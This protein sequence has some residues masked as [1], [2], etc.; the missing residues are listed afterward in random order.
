MIA[1]VCHLQ[2]DFVLHLMLLLLLLVM[3][4]VM[5]RR[6]LCK[7]AERASE[8]LLLLLLRLCVSSPR[9]RSVADKSIRRRRRVA[10]TY[11]EHSHGGRRVVMRRQP[12]HVGRVRIIII[13]TATAVRVAVFYV[14][15]DGH[16]SV[17]GGW[18]C[19]GGGMQVMRVVAVHVSIRRRKVE[20]EAVL[21][22]VC[23][24][25]R[26]RRQFRQCHGEEE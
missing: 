23:G 8:L 19:V 4:L 3:M 25:R 18:L 11:I 22:L 20:W 1:K 26:R 2:R 21:H 14:H 13:D 12:V 5:M 24:G 9:Q 10:T 17:V 16:I 15:R 6:R 7:G